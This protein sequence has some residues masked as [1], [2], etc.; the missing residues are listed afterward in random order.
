MGAAAV[1]LWWARVLPAGCCRRDV[2]SDYKYVL[3]DACDWVSGLL[4]LLLLL[5]E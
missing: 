3:L 2:Q 5:Q 4:L 1:V